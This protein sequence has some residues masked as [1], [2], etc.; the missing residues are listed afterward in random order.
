MLYFKKPK[1]IK[2]ILVDQQTIIP[3]QPLPNDEH[4]LV[5]KRNTLFPETAWQGLHVPESSDFLDIILTNKEFQPR[6]IMEQDA[7]YKQ[8]I[9][10]LVFCHN[11]SYF[12]MQRK[13]KASEQRLKNKYSFGIGGHIRQDDII[14]TNIADW[15]KRE[16][17][18][19]VDYHGN[20]TIEPFGILNDDSNNVGKVHVAFVYI[21]HGDSDAISVKEEL[22]NGTLLSLDACKEYYDSMESWSQIVFDTLITRNT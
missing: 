18:E 3:A 12:L 11:G 21:L 9:P 6:S 16:F 2:R 14:N 1:T 5:V 13:A 22:Q 8:I 15:A 17:H 7:R 20:F 4:I 10:Y 19:E